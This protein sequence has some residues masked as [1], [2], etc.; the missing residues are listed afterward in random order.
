MHKKGFFSYL[1]KMILVFLL[2]FISNLGFAV[3]K[4]V[5][6]KK[7]S[8]NVSSVEATLCPNNSPAPAGNIEFC[9][10]CK[11]GSYRLLEGCPNEGGTGD[12]CPQGGCNGGM[13]TEASR[14][15]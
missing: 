1:E 2:L 15:N 7:I 9:P 12:S 13:P 3:E 10:K 4:A 11:N 5:I 8:R 6:S 14:S